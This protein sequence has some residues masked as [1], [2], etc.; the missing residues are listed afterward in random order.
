[1]RVKFIVP[2][3][4]EGP[5]NR[6][7]IEQY[8]PYL[9]QKGI[10]YS[11]RPFWSKE[12][13]RI[14]YQTGYHFKKLFFFLL[15]TLARMIDTLTLFRDD[16]IFIHRESYP[17]K[18]GNI[19]F[20]TALGFFRKP[21]IFDFDDAIFLPSFSKPNSFIERFKSYKKINHIIKV[22]TYV[23]A[24]NSYLAD[25]AR[26]YNKSVAI[27]P[28]SIDTENYY[29]DQKNRN[30]DSSHKVTI[31]WT[32]SITTLEFLNM[33]RNI[34]KKLSERY[35]HVRFKI[36]GGTFM[37]N[38]LTNLE[39]KNWSLKDEK[40]DVKSFDIGIMPMPD[41]EWTRGK[42]GFKAILYMSMGIPCVCSPVG[43]NKEIIADG[44]NGF[45]AHTQEEWIEKL[46]LLIESPDLR[47]RIGEA[48]RLT[49]EKRYSIKANFPKFIEVL[50][51]VYIKKYGKN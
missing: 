47:K 50:N 49:V 16:I 40:E 26:K 27:I 25:F 2:Y 36:I 46:S 21:A 9:K 14:L 32:G 29:P 38:G 15:G 43:V 17:L 44:I 7:R 35:S 39:S 41:N 51:T 13:F 11:L 5:S 10:Q 45:L 23:I 12:A 24:G 18:C 8:L 1:M 33:M 22:S 3:P 48:G 31:G 19:L 20:L 28:T 42:C 34:F 37:V 4:T 6:Y 30:D